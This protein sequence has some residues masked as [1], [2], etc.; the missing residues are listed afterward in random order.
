M[1]NLQE[2]SDGMTL[3]GIIAECFETRTVPLVLSFVR[4]K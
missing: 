4:K 2:I 3:D 1:A